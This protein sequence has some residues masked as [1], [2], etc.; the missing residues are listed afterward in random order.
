MAKLHSEIRIKSVDGIGGSDEG[1][2]AKFEAGAIIYDAAGAV[3]RKKNGAIGSGSWDSLNQTDIRGIKRLQ[4]PHSDTVENFIVTVASKDATHRYDGGSS[5]GFKIDG[6][7]A[8]LIQLV[9]GKTYKFKQED[10]TNSSHRLRFYQ[11][12]DKSGG[13]YTT[14]VTVAGTLGSSGAYTQIVVSDTTP[15]YLHYQCDA[16]AYMGNAVVAQTGKDAS[17]TGVTNLSVT[18][19]T[20]SLTVESS[21]GNNVA[22]PVADASNWG[23]MSD[24]LFVKLNGIEASADVT[25][26]GNVTSA[27]AVMKSTVTTKGDIYAAS[28]SG[29][30]IRL[31]SGT[32]GKIL[33]ADNTTSSGLVWGDVSGAVTNL[34]VAATNS[35]FAVNSS[36]GTNAALTLADTDNWGVMSDEMFDQLA[37]LNTNA[38]LKTTVNAKGDLLAAS[39]DD[40]VIRLAIGVSNGHVLT[41]DSGETTGM[42]WA[43]ASGGSARTV[44]VDTNGD[45]SVNETLGG[46]EALRIKQGEHMNITESA[47]IVNFSAESQSGHFEKNFSAGNITVHSDIASKNGGFFIVQGGGSG[48]SG[49]HRIACSFSSV[50]KTKPTPKYEFFNKN[51][52][53]QWSFRK[54]NGVLKDYTQTTTIAD[55]S[56]IEILANQYLSIWYNGSEWRYIVR[57]V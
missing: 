44:Q 29:A 30:V 33:K 2:P 9:P 53:Y 17:A 19:N 21:S 24:E 55:G 56:D 46:S 47:G 13:T 12:A 23:V 15:A 40:T 8:P 5:S 11:N 7:F 48:A 43:A 57:S 25:D 18:A 38:L 49:S 45:G 34:T 1:A 32:N 50:S 3:Y 4:F 14:G 39:A 35:S 26:S 31:A 41:I 20:S 10:G 28:G 36:T 37:G 52:G 16:H 27:G 22:L 51:A 54:T 6:V 42:K